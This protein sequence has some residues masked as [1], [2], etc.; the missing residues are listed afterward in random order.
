V[1]RNL[2]VIQCAILYREYHTLMK[3][4]IRG[5]GTV[6]NYGV[7]SLVFADDFQAHPTK[8]AFLYYQLFSNRWCS[9]SEYML[10]QAGWV[11]ELHL[12]DLKTMRSTEL[13]RARC[14]PPIVS[15]HYSAKRTAIVSHTS[16]LLATATLNPTS[17]FR[18]YI[19][20]LK[21]RSPTKHKNNKN[22]V[23]N[24]INI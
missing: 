12:W 11:N 2:F 16:A 3:V 4:S 1:P 21:T 8:I 10:G 9:S 18:N 13:R 5:N 7:M 22:H 6:S 15:W 20:A 14:Q 17:F 23:S 24:R 19:T